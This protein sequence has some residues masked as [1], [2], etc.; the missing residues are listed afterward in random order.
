MSLKPSAEFNPGNPNTIEGQREKPTWRNTLRYCIEL[1]GPIPE[2]NSARKKEK[3]K[4]KKPRSAARNGKFILGPSFYL[5]G[6]PWKRFVIIDGVSTF[7]RLGICHPQR[8]ASGIKLS[9]SRTIYRVINK[10]ISLSIL[11]II[12]TA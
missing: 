5:D 2:S 6:S 4:K 10:K 7:S 3:K 11:R 9:I 12:L 1:R 8:A